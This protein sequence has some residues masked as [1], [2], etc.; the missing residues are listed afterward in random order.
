MELALAT[1][2]VLGLTACPDRSQAPS[3]P[4]DPKPGA[5]DADGDGVADAGDNCPTV[6]NLD[7]RDGDGDGKGDA[8]ECLGVTCT[9]QDQCHLAGACDPATGACTN[10]AKTDGAACDDGS[11]CTLSD[12][13]QAG[14]CVG[15]SPVACAAQ[16]QCHLA[17]ACDPATGACTNPAK[18]DGTA[19]SDGNACT[20]SDTCQ[21][22]RCVGASP[23]AC[24]ARDQCHLAGACDPATGACTNPAKAN[25]TACDDG[26]ACTARDACTAGL[27]RG[28]ENCRNGGTLG[29]QSWLSGSWHITASTPLFVGDFNGDGRDD[30]AQSLYGSPTLWVGLSDGTRFLPQTWGAFDALTAAD[31]VVTGDYDGD[32]RADLAKVRWARL[33]PWPASGAITVARSTGTTFA[34]SEW[35]GGRGLMPSGRVLP[36]DF[37]HDGRTD[38]AL[39]TPSTGDVWVARSTGSAFTL[40]D[41]GGW[42]MP[43]TSWTLTGDFDGDGRADL[44][45]VAGLSLFPLDLSVDVVVGRST[46]TSFSA[47]PWLQGWAAMPGDAFFA[48]D[49]DGDGRTDLIHVSALTPGA[50]ELALST[51][52]SFAPPQRWD[53]WW[54]PPSAGRVVGDFNG[55]HRADLLKVDRGTPGGVFVGLSLGNMFDSDLW[56]DWHTTS[57]WTMRVGDFDGDGREDLAG[58]EPGTPGV[59]WVGLSRVRSAPFDGVEP[60]PV[61]AALTRYVRKRASGAFD[62]YLDAT[63]GNPWEESY[64]QADEP[65]AN[66]CGPTAGKNLLAWYGNSAVTYA[67]LG[68]AMS[69]N[70]WSGG[71]DF[72]WICAGLCFLEPTCTTA[73]YLGL[74]VGA[75]AGTLPADMASALATYAPPGYHLVRLENDSV[76]LRELLVQVSAG[77]PVVFLES[78]GSGNLHWA[79]VTGT[80]V[81]G[82][83]LTIRIANAVNVPVSTFLSNWSLEKVGGSTVRSALAELGI[84]PYV[85]MYY[86]R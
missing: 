65:S 84:V 57:D 52:T 80:S 75:T 19:C 83:E 79:V 33:F 10:P 28:Y 46:G 21:A 16:D 70:S 53:T 22:G 30:V 14:R 77:N 37:D 71:F 1:A 36:G 13:C 17:G 68:A 61:S 86:D 59:V 63:L 42:S 55:D 48:V 62:L 78:E 60:V 69:T 67:A 66:Y 54:A 38:L 26:N 82:T 81:L 49:V 41:W 31:E 40:A 27:C 9:A 50:V 73:C 56:A 45:T 76:A 20:L 74:E 11:A 58:F 6:S 72:A 2:L 23:V 64:V 12:T 3:N 18:T 47:A 15:A 51:G 25:G 24:A 44:A 35:F 7:Q 32:G 34:T 5:A 85:M 8:C 43:G 39:V 29:A 4:G